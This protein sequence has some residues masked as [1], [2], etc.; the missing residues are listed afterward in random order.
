[1]KGPEPRRMAAACR[2]EMP[3]PDRTARPHGRH[4]RRAGATEPPDA[5]HGRFP[6]AAML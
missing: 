3:D 4:A 5:R 2:V 6:T 1:M